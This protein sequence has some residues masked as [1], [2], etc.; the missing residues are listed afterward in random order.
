[1][2]SRGNVIERSWGFQKCKNLS[3]LFFWR[4]H[5]IFW[6]FL[7]DYHM[8]VSLSSSDNAEKQTSE[9]QYILYK[10]PNIAICWKWQYL[11]D[12]KDLQMA[13]L[14]GN[15]FSYFYVQTDTGSK[16]QR[17]HLYSLVTCHVTYY[18]FWKQRMVSIFNRMFFR[19]ILVLFVPVRSPW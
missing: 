6:R 9:W 10:L 17:T 2:L 1:M 3:G 7:P 14:P 12:P 11:A 15:R 13:K 5:L 19:W 18:R 16:Q 8:I 4:V